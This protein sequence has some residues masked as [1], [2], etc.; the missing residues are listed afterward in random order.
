MS[1]ENNNSQ[2]DSLYEE[3]VKYRESKTSEETIHK[4]RQRL[5]VDMD[6][7][8]AVFTPV[9]ELETL[10]EKGYFLDQAPHENVV[11]AIKE[12]IAD[13]SDVEVNI[14]SAYL[15]DSPY[16]LKEKNEWLDKYLPE[17][18]QANRV[19]V[20]CGS[21][22]KDGIARGIRE[23]DFLLDDFTKNLHDWQPPAR[24]IKLL[25]SINHSKGSW[26]HDRI[27]YDRDP[28]DLASGIVGI[29]RNE[30]Q[31]FDEKVNQTTRK[32][33]YMAESFNDL[34]REKA[35]GESPDIQYNQSFRNNL[36]N[37]L[38]ERYGFKVEE[39]EEFDEL[40]TH[41]TEN[42]AIEIMGAFPGESAEEFSVWLN[43][44]QGG[45][46]MEK[47]FDQLLDKTTAMLS[48]YRVANTKEDT[49]EWFKTQ[50]KATIQ[51]FL[52]NHKGAAF[53]MMTP[54]GYLY[55][56]PEKA[57][58]LLSGE[59]KKG[60]LGSQTYTVDI[61]TDEQLKQE[62]INANFNDGTWNLLSDYKHEIVQE[63]SLFDISGNMKAAQGNN[64]FVL[65][66]Q[67]YRHR[68][69]KG[70]N[71]VKP[72]QSL[73]EY[74]NK[75]PK[76]WAEKGWVKEVSPDALSEVQH[77]QATSPPIAASRQPVMDLEP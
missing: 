57:Q 38:M 69:A 42:H 35:V 29:M 16:A 27:R 64:V 77:D 20:P 66:E 4:P 73:P 74:K 63:Q 24:G 52:E 25:N 32:E 55:L 76:S 45:M 11:A 9:R 70:L 6:G 51:E 60:H 14:L 36:E 3:D 8:L 75:V 31:I 10:Y 15:T 28:T 33:E 17:I 50:S 21:D 49:L 41:F 34:H 71:D 43:S 54:G 5:F 40:L 62:V 65:S 53:D 2:A 22:K 1:Q 39:G 19:F 47:M 37:Q 30:R 7:T 23:D 59:D 56:T 67:G 12:I 26:E 61:P 58:S 48:Y 18:N 72:G 68:A 13:Y 46:L 44:E